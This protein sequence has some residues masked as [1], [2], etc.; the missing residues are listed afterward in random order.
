MEERRPITW[1]EKTH[2]GV[3]ELDEMWIL[4]VLNMSQLA[5]KAL[6]ERKTHYFPNGTY[7]VGRKEGDVIVRDKSVSRKHATVEVATARFRPKDLTSKPSIILSDHSKFGTTVNNERLN[8]AKRELCDGDIVKFGTHDTIYKVQ[9]L[10]V[11]ICS[12]N[13]PSREKVFLMKSCARMGFHV[14]RTWRDEIT[15]MMTRSPVLITVKFLRALLCGVPVVTPDWLARVEARE[16]SDEPLPDEATC[17]LKLDDD[18]SRRSENGRVASVYAVDKKRRRVFRDC[19]FVFLAPSEFVWMVR[20]G[21]GEALTFYDMS[22]ADV[23]HAI[24]RAS[25]HRSDVSD[26]RWFYVRPYSNLSSQLRGE[27]QE[28]SQGSH[29]AEKSHTW[30]KRLRRIGKVREIG[31]DR[32]GQTI[33]SA[34]ITTIGDESVDPSVDREGRSVVD[35][36][37]AKH[38]LSDATPMISSAIVN[39]DRVERSSRDDGVRVNSLTKTSRD[40]SNRLATRPADCSAATSRDDLGR[41]DDPATISSSKVDDDAT[42]T[43]DFEN[44]TYNQVRRKLKA[45]GARATGRKTVLIERLHQLVQIE[46]A[47]HRARPSEVQSVNKPAIEQPTIEQPTIEH[48]AVETSTME[49]STRSSS[50]M[51]RTTSLTSNR[52]IKKTETEAKT[53]W[54][55]RRRRHDANPSIDSQE[56]KSMK[57]VIDNVPSTQRR[58]WRGS[59]RRA[60]ST[61]NDTAVDVPPERLNIKDDSSATDVMSRADTS[62]VWLFKKAKTKKQRE[63]TVQNTSVDSSTNRPRAVLQTRR[64]STEN[65]TTRTDP[66][67]GVDY[68][69]FRKNVHLKSTR[70]VRFSSKPFIPSETEEGRKRRSL[71]DDDEEVEKQKDTTWHV[72]P[73][74]VSKTS[75]TKRRRR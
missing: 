28:S 9:F 61:T 64:L 29:A 73:G 59:N 40:R 36:E 38:H 10:D 3:R 50:D 62:G 4:H 74:A 26:D 5:S 51:V 47:K 69:R 13:L 21:G 14:T 66:S 27:S 72:N 23:T 71:F 54:L 1:R 25:R 70:V 48:P 52:N 18:A 49:T 15:H 60:P 39:V 53:S 16:S 35:V 12:T 6:T 34:D 37:I 33:L 63:T 20:R 17:L 31:E 55:T 11:V 19:T 57:D 30:R 2:R 24:E 56:C 7:R 43:I 42:N 67:N 44:I 65:K 8:N 75:K 32:I 46:Q 41:V 45:R 58:R 22:E 68:K